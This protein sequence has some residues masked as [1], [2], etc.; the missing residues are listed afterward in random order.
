ML[1]DEGDNEDIPPPAVM[2]TLIGQHTTSDVKTLDH[3][4]PLESFGSPFPAVPVTVE[5][6][7]RARST[8][9]DTRS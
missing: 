6:L 8:E 7:M 9:R 3:G 5:D 4:P 2:S 1:G